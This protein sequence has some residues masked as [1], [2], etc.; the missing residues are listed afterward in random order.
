MEA[1]GIVAYR[2]YRGHQLCPEKAVIVRDTVGT[3]WAYPEDA[4]I[5]HDPISVRAIELDHRHLEAQAPIPGQGELPRFNYRV[6]FNAPPPQRFPPSLNA[7]GRKKP[8]Q[9]KAVH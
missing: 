6:T 2:V 9:S 1:I 4:D 7:A 5:Q 8:P 3:L